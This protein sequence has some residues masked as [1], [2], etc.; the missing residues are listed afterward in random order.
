MCTLKLYIDDFGAIFSAQMHIYNDSPDCS[1]STLY[2]ADLQVCIMVLF[3][4]VILFRPK[5]SVFTGCPQFLNINNQNHF[6]SLV[7]HSVNRQ[8]LSVDNHKEDF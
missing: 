4:F 5:S 3:E 6:M 7:E 1:N 2:L 8:F